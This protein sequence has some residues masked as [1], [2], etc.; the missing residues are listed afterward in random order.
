LRVGINYPWLHCG[1]D[2][3]PEPPGYGPRTPRAELRADLTRLAQAGVR[4]V[5]W[6]VLADGFSYGTGAEAPQRERGRFRFAATTKLSPPFLEDFVALLALCGEL[7]LQ[8]LPVVIDHQFAFPGLDRWSEDART[9]QLWERAPRKA[10]K[11]SLRLLRAR[12]RASRLPAGYVKGGRADAITDVQVT[13]RFVHNALVPLLEASKHH[14]AAIY[15]W[16]LINEPEW[17]MRRLPLQ[18]GFRMSPNVVCRFMQTG[19][20]AI[21]DHGFAATI[22]FARAKTLR[23]LEGRLPALSLNQV[24]YYPRGPLARLAEARFANGKPSVLGEFATRSDLLGPWP[25]LPG[26]QQEI[27]ARLAHARAKGYEAALLWS[28]RARDRAT[29]EDRALLEQELARYTGG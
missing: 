7:G 5:R 25:D 24:H 10:E 4:I 22:G 20:S 8:L 12:E 16:E 18:P 6:F 28:Y 3:G 14:A 26:G 1:W 27:A 19:L 21:R 2:F 9:L 11:P 15:A 29:L 13:R 17:I 23:A